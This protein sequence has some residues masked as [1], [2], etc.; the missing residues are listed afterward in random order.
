MSTFHASSVEKLIQRIT[1]NPIN[2]PKTYMDNLNLVICQNAIHLPTGMIRRVTSINEIVGYD[3][4]G[5]TFSFIE[6][7][8]W[9]ATTDTFE[10]VADMNSYLLE[11]KIAPRM[12][13]PENQIKKVYKEIERRERILRKL[14]EAKIDGF[15]DL[16]AMLTKL[17]EEG[18][19]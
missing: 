10:F 14:H 7:F 6:V 17:E 15:Y 9:N 16:F 18:M 2:V 12:G 11:N 19:V 4:V 3:P 13:I 1:G 5:D 8:R